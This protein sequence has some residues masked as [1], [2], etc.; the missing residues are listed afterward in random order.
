MCDGR[1]SVLHRLR[2][3]VTEPAARRRPRRGRYVTGG[4]LA[5]RRAPR[6][7]RPVVGP[8]STTLA[9]MPLVGETLA[10]RYRIDA[11]LGAGATAVVYQAHDLRLGRDVAVKVLLPNLAARSARRRPV[12]SRGARPGRRGA[13]RHRVGLR[14][15]PGRPGRR[16][17]ALLRHGTVRGRVAGG[18]PRLGGRP[19][20][21]GSA[22]ADAGHDRRRPR[23]PARAWR[24]P[25]R[26]QAAQHPALRERRE[27]CRLR[28]RPRPGHHPA[29]GCGN[30]RRGPSPI[31]PRNCSAAPSPA[32][33]PTCT[34]SASSAFQALHRPPAA[35]V[36]L[37]G[38]PRG[39]A[40]DA[41]VPVSAVAP[42]LGPAFD[43]VVGAALSPD[44]A[45]RPSPQAFAAGLEQ[46]LQQWR[47]QRPPSI[48]AGAPPRPDVSTQQIR[49]SA[50]AGRAASSGVDVG[51]RRRSSLLGPLIAAIALGI[52]AAIV[53]LILV[54]ARRRG[55]WAHGAPDDRARPSRPRACRR[56]RRARPHPRRRP[57]RRRRPPRRHRP[58]A[59]RR[60]RRSPPG[61][62]RSRPTRRSGR[63]VR[64]RTT[65]ATSSPP[66]TT[67]T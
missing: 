14:R 4:R 60:R 59:R 26:R 42:D 25:S 48:R 9:P 41:V 61:R 13:S 39:W 35:A 52:L 45:R 40:P 7:R 12:R 66:S 54:Q 36:D 31:S 58:P 30:R 19:R 22:R 21:A 11:A 34:A 16:A 8:W 50:G 24:H 18:R 1:P 44:P 32:R 37:D 28:P 2:R 3:C 67:P 65:C 63:R 56:P 62:H 64:R 15:R 27:T 55:S 33:R 29:D 53:I 20:V 6:P 38:R 51:R 23:E 43:G 46:A 57:R 47:V 49:V 10:G 17:R 5:A